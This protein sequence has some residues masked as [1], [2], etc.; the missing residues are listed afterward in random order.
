VKITASYRFDE[1]FRALKNV[2]VAS[3]TLGVNGPVF[4]SSNIDRSYSGPM[5]RLTTKF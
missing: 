3:T 4:L 5:L 2:T 1:Y